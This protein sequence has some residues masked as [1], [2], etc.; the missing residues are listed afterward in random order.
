MEVETGSASR[1]PPKR[2]PS[3]LAV[4]SGCVLAAGALLGVLA[5]TGALSWA[6]AGS[7][8]KSDDGGDALL[9]DPAGEDDA[10]EGDAGEGDAGEDGGEGETA[11]GPTPAPSPSP[12][13]APTTPAPTLA[14]CDGPPSTSVCRRSACPG[15]PSSPFC[16]PAPHSPGLAFSCPAVQLATCDAAFAAS[17]SWPAA[18]DRD[19]IRGSDA[20]TSVP[21]HG[22][23]VR[24]SSLDPCELVAAYDEV[25]SDGICLHDSWSWR[26]FID[27]FTTLMGMEFYFRLYV[28]E[29]G[30]PEENYRRA[31]CDA[32]SYFN[33][34]RT[35][36][37]NQATWL[38]ELTRAKTGDGT[39][40]I[41]MNAKF[42]SAADE[43]ADT[44]YLWAGTEQSSA[45]E[46]PSGQCQ[47]YPGARMANTDA[48]TSGVDYSAKNAAMSYMFSPRKP[49]HQDYSNF[50]H[51]RFQNFLTPGPNRTSLER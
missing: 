21:Y 30:G 3:K 15:D 4:V 42:C 47:A 6:A 19:R 24:R 49:P 12:T 8:T 14:T 50:V 33:D 25:W 9:P 36:E 41:D 26:P 29:L 27:A 37:D 2:G 10:S 17:A 31:E 18:A 35:S 34:Y 1:P 38:R 39:Q 16:L 22:R 45:E 5:G 7:S 48:G 51:V 32:A 44:Q 40:T 23:A 28:M 43:L 11:P 46:G 13:R 20:T